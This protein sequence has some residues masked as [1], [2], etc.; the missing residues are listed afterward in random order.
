[1]PLPPPTSSTPGKHNKT[2]AYFAK[3]CTKFLVAHA[4]FADFRVKVAKS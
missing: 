4:N 2:H 1:M 3:N